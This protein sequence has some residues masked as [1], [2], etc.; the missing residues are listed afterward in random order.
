LLQLGVEHRR[1]RHAEIVQGSADSGQMI[2]QDKVVFG[3]QRQC[4][5]GSGLLVLIAN[6]FAMFLKNTPRKPE[7]TQRFVELSV[8]YAGLRDQKFLCHVATLFF[9]RRSSRIALPLIA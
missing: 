9:K 7:G 6:S 1:G 3:K 8:S 4:Y 5:H 2:V